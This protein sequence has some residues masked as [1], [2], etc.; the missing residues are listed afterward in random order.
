MGR[1]SLSGMRSLSYREAPL[2]QVP[3]AFARLQNH[4]ERQQILR[5][6]AILKRHGFE[7]KMDVRRLPNVRPLNK[8]VERGAK[9]VLDQVVFSSAFLAVFFLGVGLLQGGV[10]KLVAEARDTRLHDAEVSKRAHG[11]G[12]CRRL[13]PRQRFAG[14]VRSRQEAG[15]RCE[16]RCHCGPEC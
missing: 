7:V 1:C 2:L 9:I 6:F 3:L 14:S 11:G 8:W 4:R 16:G 13:A 10:D 12:R 5:S 15:S